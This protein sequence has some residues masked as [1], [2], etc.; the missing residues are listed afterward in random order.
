MVFC[1]EFVVNCV[2]ERG[3]LDGGFSALKTC[4]LLEI[5][6]RFRIGEFDPSG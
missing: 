3:A 4:Q 6:F 2:V 1:G 5:Y